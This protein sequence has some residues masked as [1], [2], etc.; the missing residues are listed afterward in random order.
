MKPEHETGRNRHRS[1]PLAAYFRNPCHF[2]FHSHPLQYQPLPGKSRTCL[3]GPFGEVLRATGPMAKANPFRF[4]TKFQDD[5]TDLLY[6]GYRY[7][8]ANMGRWPN[9]DPLGER[10]GLNLYGFVGNNPLRYVD[11]LGAGPYPNDGKI[12]IDF[13][14]GGPVIFTPNLP[15]NSPLLPATEASTP[16]QGAAGAIPLAAELLAACLEQ[17]QLDHYIDE[18]LKNCRAKAKQKGGCCFGCCVINLYLVTG[19]YDSYRNLF[20]SGSQFFSKPCFSVQA[21]MAVID[22]QPGL[23][24]YFGRWEYERWWGYRLVNPNAPDANRTRP[25]DDQSHIRRYLDMLS[26][27]AK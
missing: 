25:I 3:E 7:Y 4:S 22:S 6:Y 13:P 20:S 27:N 16:M 19:K 23:E 26:C 12:H 1:Q 18:G 2:R 21:D 8:N 15:P 14:K 5:E 10:G 24:P 11:D 17:W 9:R